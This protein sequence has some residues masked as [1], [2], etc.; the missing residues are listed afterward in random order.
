MKEWLKSRPLLR[1]FDRLAFVIFGQRDP[2]AKKVGWLPGSG[3]HGDGGQAPPYVPYNPDWDPKLRKRQAR[4]RKS[5][6]RGIDR[7]VRDP[8][9]PRPSNADGQTD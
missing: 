7:T 6:S 5:E 3:G 1:A 2:N 9:K 4:N 8:E